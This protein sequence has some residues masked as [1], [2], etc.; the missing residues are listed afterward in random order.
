MEHLV[1][2]L[3]YLEYEKRYSPHTIDAYRRDL[4]HFAA[5]LPETGDCELWGRVDFK[6][7]RRWIVALI[8][9][10]ESPRTV[11]RKIVA[12]RSFF[13][14]LMKKGLISVNPMEKVGLLKID[15]NLPVFVTTNKMDELLDEE[16]ADP[17]D[18]KAMRNKLVLEFFYMTGMRLSE[19][20]HL[21]EHD[22]DTGA[23]TV[24]VLGKRNKERIIPLTALFCDTVRQYISLKRSTFPGAE[25]LF[26]LD[27]G[28]PLYE[29]WVQRLT[30]EKLGAVTTMKKRS[31]HVLRHSFATNVLDNGADL[32]AIKEIL[33]HANLAATQVYTHSS[34]KRIKKV[35]NQAHPRA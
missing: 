26:I 4:S 35:Y 16:S 22:V 8:A 28:K 5:F 17:G 13:K 9:E 19:L 21:K 31:P 7:I 27:S 29:R 10:G 30:S 24:K 34:L 23:M 12:L 3:Q 32:N 20:I 25:L 18:F 14:Y 6:V 2:Y 1:S 15:K 11:N 33:G